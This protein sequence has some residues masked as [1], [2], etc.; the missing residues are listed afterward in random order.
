[1]LLE[2]WRAFEGESNSSS[3]AQQQVG[4]D[5]SPFAASTA[6]C[7]AGTCVVCRASTPC[8]TLEVL[9]MMLSLF[10]LTCTG[11]PAAG[12]RRSRR[13]EDAQACQA[14]APYRDG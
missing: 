8:P 14:Q 11:G 1:M 12:R 13:N 4:Q 9:W 7:E 10:L 5:G 2:A 3:L 6:P